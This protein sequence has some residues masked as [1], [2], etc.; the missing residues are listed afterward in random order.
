MS[1][2][3]NLISKITQDFSSFYL[4]YELFSLPVARKRHPFFRLHPVKP[5]SIQFF[6][7]LTL[8]EMRK[9]L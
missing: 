5:L 7:T 1:D 3:E 9:G 2:D 8:E 4:F 6:P